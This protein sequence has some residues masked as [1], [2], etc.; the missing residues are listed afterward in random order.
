VW[1]CSWAPWLLSV[2]H[3]DR[4]TATSSM[5]SPTFGHQSLTSMPLAP[6]LR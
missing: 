4:T 3:S 2:V 6:R 1:N 5:Q